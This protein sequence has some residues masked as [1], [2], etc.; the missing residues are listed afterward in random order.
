M[1]T[2]KRI[3]A[4]SPKSGRKFGWFRAPRDHRN[5]R[6]VSP[7]RT[8]PLPPSVDLRPN[9]PPVYDQ[10]ALGSC[11][12]NASGA[13]LEF[14]QIKQG[15][16]PVTPSR[17][18]IYYFE[19]LDQG[20]VADDTGSTITEACKVLNSY[21]APAETTW[22]YDVSAFAIKPSN[23][24]IKEGALHTAIKYS[25][26]AQDET[27][28]KSAIASGFPIIFGIQVFESFEGDGPA[29]TGVIPM[30]SDS[31]GLM[32]GH[33]I[34]IVGY[35]D[36]T[37]LFTFRNSWG[38]SW[39]DQGYGYLPYEYVLNSQLAADFWVVTQVQ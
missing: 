27:S 21:G 17:L 6:F 29:S 4:V 38:T 8:G 13:A 23:D 12:A 3:A 36:S 19:R 25:E 18:F 30:P 20:D 14:D 39:G 7:L 26:V 31:D 33:A 24:A 2:Q 32:G 1:D 34:C 37:K 35:N 16:Q 28:I 10:G 15:Q 9:C 22:P 11:S 5:L